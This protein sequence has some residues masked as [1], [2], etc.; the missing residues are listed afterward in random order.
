[1]HHIFQKTIIREVKWTNFIISRFQKS[2][3]KGFMFRK[4]ILKKIK[5]PFL[6]QTLNVANAS[7]ATSNVES[8]T[9]LKKF[10]KLGDSSI[11]LQSASWRRLSRKII[12]QFREISWFSYLGLSKGWMIKN[13]ST[14]RLT[15]SRDL[16]FRL[17]KLQWEI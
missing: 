17:Y 12:P 5:E 10:Q 9:Y 8:S 16:A 11:V 4:T 13:Q 1:M 6:F 15:S 2:C 3:N 7:D 14:Q